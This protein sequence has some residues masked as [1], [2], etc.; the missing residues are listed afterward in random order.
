MYNNSNS[1]QYTD[2]RSPIM[3]HKS[4][5]LPSVDGDYLLSNANDYNSTSHSNQLSS[6]PDHT[7]IDPELFDIFHQTAVG[8]NDDSA[9]QYFNTPHSSSNNMNNITHHNS[10]HNL[11]NLHT[12][13]NSPLH[14]GLNTIGANSSSNNL[15]SHT[16]PTL[17]PKNYSTDSLLQRID[18]HTQ[19][20]RINSNNDILNLYSTHNN[21]LHRP[22]QSPTLFHN[23]AYNTQYP[24]STPHQSIPLPNTPSSYQFNDNLHTTKL[25][26]DTSNGSTNNLFPSLVGLVPVNNLKQQSST[27]NN[28]NSTVLNQQMLAA[29]GNSLQHSTNQS[30][31]LHQLQPQ[32]VQQMQSHPQQYNNS[33]IQQQQA[34][35]NQSHIN[36]LQ[37]SFQKTHSDHHTHTSQY[38]PS[39]GIKL[40]PTPQFSTGSQRRQLDENTVQSSSHRSNKMAKINEQSQVMNN[41]NNNTET[42]SVNSDDDINADDD[43]KDRSTKRLARKAELARASRRRKKMYVQ[44]L[45]IKVK[46]LG[47]K[48]EELQAKAALVRAKRLP[49][50]MNMEESDRKANQKQIRLAMGELANRV[51]LDTDTLAKLNDYTKKFVENSRERQSNVDFYMDRVQECL[52]P[53]LQVKFAM[54][55]LDQQDEFYNKPGL[56]TSLMHKEVG[57]SDAQMQV[58][59]IV[60][61]IMYMI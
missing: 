13:T 12:N 50:D 34:G 36:A 19:L 31:T 49:S 4:H 42:L 8:F 60:Y 40:E 52:T 46:K 9:H 1:Q 61:S 45:E 25:H 55:G 2:L 7:A 43:D 39:I 22:N 48:I 3:N 11:L 15:L 32:L 59:V 41:N 28:T 27:N 23:P 16:S 5:A 38:T 58:C 56:W 17:I 54:W 35:S 33:L 6:T 30:S 47:Q 26:H 37:Q 24:T 44:D 53:G 18:S 29:L 20:D 14:S 21:P 51:Q 10:D 57:L